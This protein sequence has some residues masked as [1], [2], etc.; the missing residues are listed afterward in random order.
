[1]KYPHTRAPRLDLETSGPSATT[2]T[3]EFASLAGHIWL[4]VRVWSESEMLD[5]F[6][7]ILWSAE[8]EGVGTGWGALR[9]FIEG[10]ALTA[11]LED[12]STGGCGE[13]EGGD[14][15]LGNFEET[16]RIL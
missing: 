15:H 12:A 4:L 7:G 5:C 8:E 9:K 3:L 14:G 2:G 11:G 6:T 16:C 10:E 13:A 1:M